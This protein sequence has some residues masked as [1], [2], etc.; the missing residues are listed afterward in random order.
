MRATKWGKLLG[1]SGYLCRAI[2]YG[3]RD[4]PDVPFAS[5]EVLDSIPQTVDD[6]VFARTKLEEGCRDQVYKEVTAD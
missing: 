5:G 6:K 4:I 3:A 2:G 1:S